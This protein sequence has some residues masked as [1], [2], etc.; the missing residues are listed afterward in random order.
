[1][2]I[3]TYERKKGVS[4]EDVEIVN[5]VQPVDHSKVAD[6]GIALDDKAGIQIDTDPVYDT[7][8]LDEESFMREWIEIHMHDPASEDEPQ[9]A[10]VT[11]NGD[12]VTLFRGE[13]KKVRRYHVAALAQA[14]AMRLVQSKI[15]NPDGS[16]GYV[17]KA[18][19][20]LT[21]PFSVTHEPNR[22]GSA[23][24]RQLLGNPV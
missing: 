14:K 8:S 21:Y 9:F 1:M 19:L 15:T 17:E 12:K 5:K 10:E 16:M 13:V 20:R 3:N 7:K 18:V 6:G 22:R 4:S 11:V 24:L 23:W 2:A